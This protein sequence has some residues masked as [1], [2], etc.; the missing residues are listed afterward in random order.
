MSHNKRKKAAKNK[1]ERKENIQV[2]ISLELDQWVRKMRCNGFNEKGMKLE[3]FEDVQVGILDEEM[4]FDGPGYEPYPDMKMEKY[5]YDGGRDR[6]NR[7][8]GSGSILF[9]DDDGSTMTGTWEHGIR[10]G[11]FKI[12][13]NRNG[14]RYI[15]GDYVNDS[16]NGKLMIIFHDD[17]WME[18]FFK[19]GILHGFCRYFDAKNRLTFVGMHREGKPVGTCWRIVGGGGCVVGRVDC[20]GKL[21]GPDIAYIYPDYKTA[22]VGVFHNGEMVT[23]QHC[24]VSNVSTENGTIKV[25]EFSEPTGSVFK[26]E[27]SSHDF[28]TLSPTLKDPYETNTIQVK[29]SSVPG[30]S[31]GTFARSDLQKNTILAFYNGIKLPPGYEEEDTWEENAYKIFDPSNAP[32]GALDI[33]EKHRSTAYYS[34]SLAHKTNHSFL[35]NSQFLVYDHP[36]WGVVP[37]IAST[38]HIEAGGEIFVRYGYDLDWCPDWYAEA[39]N[40]G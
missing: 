29:K 24:S 38:R 22:L 36:R 35:P 26:R 18:G 2:L 12:V 21:S 34:A 3:Q 7:F 20:D 27:F 9:D 11:L 37:C 39:W 1:L 25:A 33:L 14:V 16:M 32:D 15:E 10:E 17:T 40:N 13:T 28:V 6:E 23:A 19:D 30:A 4:T 8:H 5:V 31:E